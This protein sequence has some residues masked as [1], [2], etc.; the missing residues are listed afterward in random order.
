MSWWETEDDEDEP[1]YDE[2]DVRVRPNRRGSRPRTKVRPEHSDAVTGIVFGVDRGRYAV[3]VDEGSADEHVIT[4]ARASE[5]RRKSVVTGDRVE[6]AAEPEEDVEERLLAE[7]IER[8][9]ET[10]TPRDARVIRLY[11]GLEG[12]REHT[13]EEIG[14]MLGVTRERVRQLRDRALKRLREGDMG[15]ALQS[16]AA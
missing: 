12:G 8:A 1:E 13:L 11:F 7:H 16:F 14:N 15:S 4:A 9:L 5:L 10:L 2:S 6:E 3:L